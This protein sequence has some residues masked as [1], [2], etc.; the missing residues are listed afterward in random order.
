VKTILLT[1]RHAWYSRRF[2]PIALIAAVIWL[3]L[4]LLAY[5]GIHTSVGSIAEEAAWLTEAVLSVQQIAL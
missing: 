5:H 1:V 4:M 3:L 2:Y